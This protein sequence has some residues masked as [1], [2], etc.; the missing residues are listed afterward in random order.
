MIAMEKKENKIMDFDVRV[1][2][3]TVFINERTELN[4]MRDTVD[5]WGGLQCNFSEDDK[6]YTMIQ[7]LCDD[8][9][10]S[11]VVLKQLLNK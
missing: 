7:T 11:M 8:I 10:K 2:G 6:R 1:W 4:Y 3:N 9:S 5:K